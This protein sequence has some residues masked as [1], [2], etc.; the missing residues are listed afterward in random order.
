MK[1]ST[2]RT[3]G[4]LLSVPLLATTLSSCD[5]QIHEGICSSGEEPTWS[6]VETPGGSGCVK[7]GAPVAEGFARYPRGRV[8]QWINPPSSYEH[9]DAEGHD[10]Y[11]IDPNT[12]GYPYWDEVLAEH[13]ELTC[14][15]QDPIQE[16]LVFEG[17]GRPAD[18]P[19]LVIRHNSLGNR[20]VRVESPA[21]IANATVSLRNEPKT[22]WTLSVTA[23]GEADDFLRVATLT[24]LTISGTATTASGTPASGA[25]SADTG[26]AGA[27]YTLPKTVYGACDPAYGD[28]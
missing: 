24:C 26:V 5:F 18:A 28:G 16:T 15:A 17:S 1:T 20:C 25:G 22:D 23:P 10:A 12:Q 7:D 6:L 4:A 13:P 3:L 21:G 27:S 8:P 2:R 11:N 9:I 14:T 19:R